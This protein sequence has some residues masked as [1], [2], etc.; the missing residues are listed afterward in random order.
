MTRYTVTL[1]GIVKARGLSFK[2]AIRYATDLGRKIGAPITSRIQIT[3][4]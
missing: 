3:E 4:Q 2:D 1:D